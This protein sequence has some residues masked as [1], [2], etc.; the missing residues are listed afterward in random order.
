MKLF[1]QRFF[2]VGVFSLLCAIAI[3]IVSSMLNPSVAVINKFEKAMNKGDVKLMEK[4]FSPSVD[5][6]MLGLDYLAT[7]MQSMASMLGAKGKVKYEILTGEVVEETNEDGKV[8]KYVPTV[9]VIK[10]G[11]EVMSVSAEN[12]ELFTESG[13]DYIYTGYEDYGDDEDDYDY[14]YDFD[15]DY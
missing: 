15:F 4:C 8:I 12:M 2:Y 14:D 5:K 6:D 11:N 13:K 3:A 9:T 7:G 1:K 10:V